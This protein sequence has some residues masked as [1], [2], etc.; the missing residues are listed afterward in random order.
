MT[1]R[2]AA[3]GTTHT[4]PLLSI[5]IV[6]WNTRER[7][8]ACLASIA[9][10]LGQ[11]DHEVL[12][13]DN[14]SADGSPSMVETEFP[15]VRLIRNAHNVGFGRANNQAMRLAR[16]GHILLLNS[17]TELRDSSVA[18]LLE[19]VR[20]DPS[21]GVAHC[22]LDFPDGRSQYTAYRFPR[23]SLALVENLGLH[24]LLPKQRAGNLLLGG[25]WEPRA[26][27]DV[28]W[29]AGA[30]MLIRR[31]VFEQ[32]AGFDESVFM[33]GED[34]EWCY[35]IRDRGWRIRYYPGTSIVH[36]NHVS[37]DIRWG[38]S[39]KRVMLCL[40][41]QL[42]VYAQRHGRARAATLA[43]LGLIGA[44]MRTGYHGA[45]LGLSCGRSSVERTMCAQGL[46][47]LRLMAWVIL[48]GRR[49]S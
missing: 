17:D 7:L 26:A 37:S 35:R 8:R 11:V 5:V 36:F 19:Q 20:T 28:D 43:A 4:A 42:D 44:L 49:P 30:F 1:K 47:T 41:R 3:T 13:V 22:R 18:D 21:I 31:E 2:A 29:V 24:K 25:Y 48:G 14:A 23:L 15:A 16:G 6:N 39:D 9:A 33:Y 10:H 38:S 12:V 34:L 46:T 40:A 45:R 32:T 27:R